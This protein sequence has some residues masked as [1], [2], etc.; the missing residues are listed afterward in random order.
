M[1]PG[2]RKRSRAVICGILLYS[3]EGDDDDDDDD[4]DDEALSVSSLARSAL[5]AVSGIVDTHLLRS[6]LSRGEGD[7]TTRTLRTKAS[8]M[9]SC[10]NTKPSGSETMTSTRSCVGGTLESDVC[11]LDGFCTCAKVFVCVCLCALGKGV[12]R[13]RRVRTKLS[14]ALSLSLSLSLWNEMCPVQSRRIRCS[15]RASAGIVT[16]STLPRST[17]EA[18]K[19]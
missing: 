11:L 13:V 3:K 18:A 19:G 16:S 14:L 15:R 17:C 4:D 6:S 10:T 9:R 2:L 5:A 7:T 1:P 12:E 8:S